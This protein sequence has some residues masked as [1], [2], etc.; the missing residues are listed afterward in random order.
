MNCRPTL[1]AY[2]RYGTSQNYLTVCEVTTYRNT[3]GWVICGP[4]VAFFAGE[5]VSPFPTTTMPGPVRT[6]GMSSAAAAMQMLERKQ[7]VLANNLANASTRGFKAETAFA[8]LMDNQLAKT[9]TALDL[10]AGS[11]TETHNS[12]DLAVD[13]DGFFVTQTPNGER[14]VRNGSFRLDPERQL[15]DERGNPV[16][17]DDGPLVLPTGTVEIGNDG[18][19][20]VNGRVLQRLRLERVADGAQL[21]HE[22]GTQFVP[23]ASRQAIPP[24]ERNVRQGFLE[25]SNVNTMSA[26]TDMLAVLHRYGAAQKALTV[27]DAA[28][29]TSV[30]DLA[31]PV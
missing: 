25:E 20:K 30:N 11:L 23:D 27:L 12:L 24:A 6:N 10:T 2:P 16:L 9:D 22:G 17:G 28:R 14:F 19:V 31:K 1:A 5:F 7:Q 21:Q 8:R 18:T 4:T 15:V 3:F 29:G 13:G 26:M